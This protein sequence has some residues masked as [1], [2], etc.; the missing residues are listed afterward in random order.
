ML[1]TFTPVYLRVVLAFLHAC[2][3]NTR[4]VSTLGFFSFKA[5]C[6]FSQ[7]L[8]PVYLQ[9]E[10]TLSCMQT[11][12]HVYVVSHSSYDSCSYFNRTSS[13]FSKAYFQW[14]K[15]RRRKFKVFEKCLLSQSARYTLS[16]NRSLLHLKLAVSLVP[17]I[18][19]CRLAA[20]FGNWQTH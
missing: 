16:R 2:S 12:T 20:C 1:H 10:Y 17:V 5:N 18:F 7:C 3:S 15:K 11:S 9:S 6:C 14:Y 8:P 19:D 13:F 4:P